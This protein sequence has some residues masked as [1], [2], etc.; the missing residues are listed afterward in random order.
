[1]P[2]FEQPDLA[3]VLRRLEDE[4]QAI[5]RDRPIRPTPTPRPQRPAG[6][7]LPPYPYKD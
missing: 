4:R 5:E 2:R 1:M 3:E 6:G 7:T